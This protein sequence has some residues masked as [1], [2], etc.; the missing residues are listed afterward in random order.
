MMDKI[1]VNKIRCNKCGD[2]IESI[3]RHDFKYC[4]CGAVAVDGGKDYLR[5]CGNR[6]DWEELSQTEEVLDDQIKKGVEILRRVRARRAG[7]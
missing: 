5:R 4:K 2:E 3:D 1:V 6:E 7:K